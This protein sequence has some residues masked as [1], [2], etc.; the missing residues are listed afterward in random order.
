[1]DLYWSNEFL[2]TIK[3]KPSI[4]NCKTYGFEIWL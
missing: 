2:R 1:L 4:T 3:S